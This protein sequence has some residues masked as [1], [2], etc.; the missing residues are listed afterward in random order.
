MQVYLFNSA[1]MD[2]VDEIEIRHQ[3]V[4][5]TA[6]PAD[7]SEHLISTGSHWASF[8]PTEHV[9]IEFGKRQPHETIELGRL[10][11]SLCERADH[12]INNLLANRFS[13]AEIATDQL[14]SILGEDANLGPRLR[15]T[16]WSR[17]VLNVLPGGLRSTTYCAVRKKYVGLHFDDFGDHA[18]RSV[19]LGSLRLCVNLGSHPRFFCFTTVGFDEACAEMLIP[20]RRIQTGQ[21]VTGLASQYCIERHP[22]VY[23]LTIRPGQYYL[24]PTQNLIHDGQT[25]HEAT[26]D[27]TLAMRVG[28]ES[29]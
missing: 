19:A 27:V 10:P 9:D 18:E 1:S 21:K 3:P 23:R 14:V 29:K 24:A 26:R 17:A 7:G 6:A 12:I 8:V 20:Q 4:S 28:I 13:Q 5:I 16:P 2:Q 25:H 11:S 22:R 15:A